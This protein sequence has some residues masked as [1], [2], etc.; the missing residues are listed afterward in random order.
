MLRLYLIHILQ[1]VKYTK[2][3]KIAKGIAKN[4]T[5]NVYWDKSKNTTTTKSNEQT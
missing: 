1:Y 2:H 5:N 4:M 3:I